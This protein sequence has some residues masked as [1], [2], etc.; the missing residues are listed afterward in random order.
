[1]V[2]TENPYRSPGPPPSFSSA[3]TDR[4]LLDGTVGEEDVVA[5]LPT[6]W[7]IRLLQGLAVTVC[8]P[9]FLLFCAILISHDKDSPDVIPLL[10][11]QAFMV[12]AGWFAFGWLGRRR[13]TRRLLKANA[14][15]LGPLRGYLDD[16]GLNWYPPLSTNLHQISWTAL[17]SAA[18]KNRGIALMHST[19]TDAF[20]AIPATCVEDYD[21]GAMT[22]LVRGW[23]R[24]CAALPIY[25]T[26]E[27]WSE[28]PEGSIVFRK[29]ALAY[30]RVT[31]TPNSLGTYATI[32]VVLATSFFLVRGFLGTDY[33]LPLMVLASIL[34][35]SRFERSPQ[36]SSRLLIGYWGWLTAEGG[37][38]HSP[39]GNLDYRWSDA[40]VIEVDDRHF[41]VTFSPEEV[42]QLE[43][44]DL[45]EGDFETV[46]SWLTERMP[47][48][49][50]GR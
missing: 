47:A 20:I 49:S 39:Y 32:V 5:M 43:A 26:R 46:R 29:A 1:M 22:G 4:I 8:L 7:T 28:R 30:P 44:K 25:M 31:A 6:P 23:H 14:G 40:T 27:D 19:A 3:S 13:R 36:A 16:F 11:F 10:G 15:M 9:M 33:A 18:V 17:R 12:G 35:S 24:D 34:F 48:A 21:A 41:T 2:S 37:R 45:D 42:F 50:A 38:S